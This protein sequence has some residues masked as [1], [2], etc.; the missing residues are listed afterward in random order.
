MT[1]L[2]DGGA[3]SEAEIITAELAHDDEN[4]HHEVRP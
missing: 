2:A 4:L 3:Q 1:M